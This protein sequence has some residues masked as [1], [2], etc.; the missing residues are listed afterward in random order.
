MP[1]SV[2]GSTSS[3]RRRTRRSR[4]NNHD[5]CT[6]HGPKASKKLQ[7]IEPES[8]DYRSRQTGDRLGVLP[9]SLDYYRAY[10]RFKD[11]MVITWIWKSV[12][13]GRAR[14]VRGFQ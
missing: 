12:E 3:R 10:C 2:K 6:R 1:I 13:V 8:N 7:V 14:W 5:E 11:R 4:L 9:T